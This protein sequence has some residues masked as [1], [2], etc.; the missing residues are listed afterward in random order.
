MNQDKFII[1]TPA[2]NEANYIGKIIESIVSQTILPCEWVI[3]DDG[4]RDATKTIAERASRAHPWIKVVS[5]EDRGYR[6]HNFGMIETFYY[7]LNHIITDDCDFI[8]LIEADIVLKPKYFEGILSKFAENPR[9]GIAEGE[10]Y[11]YRNGKPVKLVTMSWSTN[12][13]AK[14]WRKKCFHEIEPFAKLHWDVIDNYKAMMLGWETRTFA[15]EE[16]EILHLRPIGSSS[17]KSYCHTMAWV[18]TLL[19]FKGT[20]PLWV[21]AAASRY[22]LNYPYVI[23]GFC[24][25]I[26]YLQAVLERAEQ[27]DDENFRRWLWKWQKNKL[28]EFL[29]WG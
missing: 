15:D 8:F 10:V 19:H 16:L 9:L 1:I 12:G 27:Y 6:S 28:L 18:G 22:M 13:Q 21:L 24:I 4:S 11:E 20:H 17:Q 23:G 29:R 26:G 2:R 5:R 25:I 14:G 7:G 3:V